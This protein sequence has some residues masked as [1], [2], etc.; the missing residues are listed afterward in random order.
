MGRAVLVPADGRPGFTLTCDE[1]GRCQEFAARFM[2]ERVLQL[3]RARREGW[4]WCHARLVE[5]RL[6]DGLALQRV[7]RLCP[8]CAAIARHAR[9]GGLWGHLLAELRSARAGAAAAVPE[10]ASPLREPP[11]PV[12]VRPSGQLDLFGHVA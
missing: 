5:H 7:P 4:G 2:G 11:A 9:E 10:P 6:D 1:C 12:H 8:T 3:G